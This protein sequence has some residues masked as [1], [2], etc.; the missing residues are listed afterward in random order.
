ML[1]SKMCILYISFFAAVHTCRSLT[2]DMDFYPGQH[3]RGDWDYMVGHTHFIHA[4]CVSSVEKVALSRSL[5]V[6]QGLIFMLIG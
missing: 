3:P 2:L 4:F 1:N 5:A 6:Q